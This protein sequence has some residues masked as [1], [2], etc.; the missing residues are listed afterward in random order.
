MVKDNGG[1][2][3]PDALDL[4]VTL[5][6]L[7]VSDSFMRFYQVCFCCIDQEHAEGTVTLNALY[8]A[9]LAF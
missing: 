3:Q 1:V 8:K 5:V 4:P 2:T 7:W 6:F 9:A